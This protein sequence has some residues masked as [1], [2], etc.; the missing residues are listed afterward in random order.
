MPNPIKYVAKQAMRSSAWKFTSRW[1]RGQQDYRGIGERFRGDYINAEV[2]V[3]FGDT[4][5]KTYQLVQWLPVLEELHKQHRV[6]LMFRRP[7]AADTIAGLT[8]LPIVFKRRFQPMMDFIHASDFR[9]AI[10][11]NNG[12]MNFQPLGYA[13]MVHVHVNHGESDKISMVSNQ[14]KAY[15]RVFVA[16]Q[17]AVDRHHRALFDFDYA[18][19]VPVGRPQLDIPHTSDLPDSDLRTVMY[20]PTWEGENEANNY[21][22]V[23]VFGPQIVKAVL[24]QPGVRMI[25]KPHPRVENSKCDAVSNANAQILALIEQANRAGGEHLV[26]MQGDIL[27]MFNDVSLMITD[28]SSVGLDFLYLKP[29]TPLLITDRRNDRA[30]LND[31]S[32]ITRATPIIDDDSVADVADMICRALDHDEAKSQ[33]ERMRSYYFGDGPL[34]NSMSAFLSAVDTLISQRNTDIDTHGLP[35]SGDGAEADQGDDTDEN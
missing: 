15:D 26:A 3:Y 29:G 33:R 10:Y 16:G 9:L 8:R 27:G 31:E 4:V 19:L 25:Y 1:L 13:P 11:V 12:V 18:K 7:S 22:S 23:D 35:R 5:S 28:I 32:P 20:A 34:G 30:Q 6:A 24:E 21:T 17:A 2:M 14:A